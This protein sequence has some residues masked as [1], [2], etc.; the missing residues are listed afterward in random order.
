MRYLLNSAVI[1]A[2]G[3]YDYQIISVDEARNWYTRG[4][5]PLSSIG[6]EQTA[7]ALGELL[8]RPIPVKRI[9]IKM[10]PGDEALV[11]RLVFPPGT[12]RIDPQDKGR[13]SEMVLRGNFELGLLKRLNPA[14]LRSGITAG[15]DRQGGMS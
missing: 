5:L 6:Y 13:L 4:L 1:T 12:G 3:L 15:Q 9:T 10:N 11:F 7:I 2:P 8:G 14:R